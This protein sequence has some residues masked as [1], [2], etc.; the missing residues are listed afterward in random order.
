LNNYSIAN[1]IKVLTRHLIGQVHTSIPA[2]IEK[3]DKKTQKADV[4][5]M[6]K[7]TYQDGEEVEYPIIPNVPLVMPRTASSGVILPVSK[8]DTVLLVFS[9][10]SID[11]WLSTGDLSSTPADQR[12]DLSDAIGIVGLFPFTETS[13]ASGDDVEVF[14][15]DAKI[16]LKKDK[17]I[18][19]ENGKGTIQLSSNGQININNGNLTVD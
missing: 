16:T 5:P 18:L 19:L 2:R 3:Y 13:Q 4:K 8:G 7:K 14:F 6:L 12:F 15:G 9:E 1:A 11:G 17:E 10:R